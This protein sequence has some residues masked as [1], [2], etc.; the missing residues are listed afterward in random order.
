[1]WT[2]G[3]ILCNGIRSYH[4]K[5]FGIRHVDAFAQYMQDFNNFAAVEISLLHSQPFTNVSFHFPVIVD[6]TTH[7]ASVDKTNDTPTGQGLGYKG[8]G[9]EVIGRTTTTALCVQTALCWIA[10]C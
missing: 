10:L 2:Q 7:V 4:L 6:L 5:L 1:M 8:E 3:G 9:P